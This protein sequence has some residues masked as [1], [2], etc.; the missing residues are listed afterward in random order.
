ML[1]AWTSVVRFAVG[2]G[3][4][5]ENFSEEGI[6]TAKVPGDEEGGVLVFRCSVSAHSTQ[7]AFCAVLSNDC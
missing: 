1:R 3:A 4:S 6:A 2:T 7:D 5:G